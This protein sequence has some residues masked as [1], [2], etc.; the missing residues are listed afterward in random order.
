MVLER[1]RGN[2][3][4]AYD[5]TKGNIATARQYMQE[6]IAQGVDSD[7][8]NEGAWTPENF[9]CINENIYGCLVE[10]NPLIPYREQAVNAHRNGQEFY[11]TKE[12]LLQEKPATQVILEAAEQD[13]KKPVAKRR[14]INLGKTKNHDIPTDSFADDDGI[15]FLARG[16]TSANKYGLF[17]KN[18]AGIPEVT[19][20]LPSIQSQDYS[21][22]CWL[23]R[24]GHGLSSDFDGYGRNLYDDVGSVFRVRGKVSAEGAQ[25]NSARETK[26]ELYSQQELELAEK[27]LE[28]LSKLLR[29]EST[30][31]L[32]NLL[33][34]L[35]Q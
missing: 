29:E 21:R 34:R 4:V 6:R 22:G 31:N 28:G 12:V 10:F 17:L 30:Q 15:V 20:Y 25:K 27:E 16:K 24:V 19:F 23:L 11:L 8:C 3:A 14:V 5:K 9:N 26:V 2:F 18:K 33:T 7:I 35:K 1:C 32:R 13:K